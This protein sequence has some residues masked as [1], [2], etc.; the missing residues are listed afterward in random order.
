MSNAPIKMLDFE[1]IVAKGLAG[2]RKILEAQ[3]ANGVSLTYRD[4]DGNL[5]EEHPDGSIII[6]QEASKRNGQK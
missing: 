3:L 4:K 5:V 6:L 2:Q 1:E